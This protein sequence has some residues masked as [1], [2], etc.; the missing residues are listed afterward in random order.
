MKVV[1]MIPARLAS[2][3]LPEKMILDLCGLPVILR[4]YEAVKATG[5][6]DEVI[7]VTD[8]KKIA[9][10]TEGHGATTILSKK[11][12]KTGS[13]RIAEAAESV[14]ADIIINVQGDE[15]F[16]DSNS[17]SALIQCFREDQEELIDLASL[18]VAIADK[19]YID[20][21]NVVKVVTDLTG[22]ALYFS[23]SAIPFHRDPSPLSRCYKHKG[24]YAFRRSALLE[25]PKLIMGPLER[26]EKIE[27]IRYLEHGKRLQMIE[28]SVDAPGIDTRADLEDAI[29][30]FK[31]LNT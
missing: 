6:F 1:A 26:A 23:R 25:F 19:T 28:T 18:M 22:K 3:R 9:T 29:A 17:L 13:D 31:K 12:H 16:I 10:L 14:P 7:I 2:S 21:P 15:P 5:L 24:V 20:N 4:T 11:D 8:S 30:N 27:A